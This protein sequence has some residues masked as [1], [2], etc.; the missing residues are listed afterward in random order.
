MDQSHTNEKQSNIQQQN[1][2]SS[3]KNINEIDKNK[4][5]TNNSQ[6]SLKINENIKN[7]NPQLE[8]EV[9]NT[10]TSEVDEELVEFINEIYN[11]LKDECK[12]H[13][14]F[15]NDGSCEVRSMVGFNEP[16]NTE[17][18]PNLKKRKTQHIKAFQVKKKKKAVQLPPFD[19][20]GLILTKMT[21]YN[22]LQDT[23]LQDFLSKKNRK[24]IL[25]KNGLLTENGFI[26]CRPNDFIEKREMYNKG[27]NLETPPIPVLGKILA[28]TKKSPYENSEHRLFKE[29]IYQSARLNEILVK[30][31]VKKISTLEPKLKKEDNLL[32]Q[33][34]KGNILK[35]KKTVLPKIESKLINHIAK[36]ESDDLKQVLN[37]NEKMND[38]F[39]INENN[40]VDH[41]SNFKDGGLTSGVDNEK[42]ED[43]CMED[44]NNGE[45]VENDGLEKNNEEE[46]IDNFDEDFDDVKEEEE[47]HNNND[48]V[49]GVRDELDQDK[50]DD[51][52]NEENLIENKE[53]KI[54]HA[55]EEP[56]LA[57]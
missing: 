5:F 47:I 14:K 7:Q 45:E 17:K 18:C 52:R 38:Q 30:I 13:T 33:S 55:N 49:N 10:S 11:T 6:K 8:P 48:E 21:E 19:M 40:E 46:K 4:K 20:K 9:K 25:I 24:E 35:Q 50:S 57:N 1:S 41:Q 43:L 27:L 56:I 31:P 3:Y 23:F 16:E 36:Q 34:I 28:K 53:E 44:A 51:V 29:K 22:A 26:I 54:V 15:F 2:K 42:Q 37:L 32:K 39:K 12:K